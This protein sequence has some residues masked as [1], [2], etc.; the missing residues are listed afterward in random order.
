MALIFGSKHHYLTLDLAPRWA[1]RKAGEAT[2]VTERVELL[3]GLPD[4][5]IICNAFTY[6]L[7]QH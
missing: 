4:R 5:V 7:E 3:S 6:Q 1:N 2:G